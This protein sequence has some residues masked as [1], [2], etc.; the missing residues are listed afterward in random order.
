MMCSLQCKCLGYSAVY[1]F[2][3]VLPETGAARAIHQVRKRY[4]WAQEQPAVNCMEED[5]SKDISSQ[6]AQ[7]RVMLT[8][9]AG[10]GQSDTFVPTA[11]DVFICTSAKCG[12]TL[13]QQVR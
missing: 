1:Q 3:A 12:T 4:E 6:M 13:M 2:L 7:L 5:H 11:G 8:A 9:A 10:F